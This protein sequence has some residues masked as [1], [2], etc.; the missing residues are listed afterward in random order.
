M[1]RLWIWI[2]LSS[3]PPFLGCQPG[4]PSFPSP[5]KDILS[6]PEAQRAGEGVF[7]KH[8]AICHGAE[9]HGDGLQA[10]NLEPRPADLRNLRGVRAEPG[11]WF[12]RI[13]E[14]GKKEPLARLHS[15]MPSWGDHLSDQQ[16]WEVVA[17][18]KSLVA[19][20]A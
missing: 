11:Y 2:C 13:K 12:F 6:S 19:G 10:I 7:L 20:Q 1:G 15:A 4:D 5:P 8:C 17:Y 14:G 16:I 18:L 9:G 3:V